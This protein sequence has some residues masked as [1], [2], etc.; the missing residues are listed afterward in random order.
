MGK[1][2]FSHV[3]DCFSKLHSWDFR[4]DGSV[5]VSTKFLTSNFYNKSTEMDAKN[6]FEFSFS[7]IVLTNFIGEIISPSGPSPRLVLG[8][9]VDRSRPRVVFPPANGNL[10][11][12]PLQT[13][14]VGIVVYL[15]CKRSFMFPLSR[16][17]CR[18]KSSCIYQVVYKSACVYISWWM[19][20]IC[21]LKRSFEKVL[22]ITS[23]SAQIGSKVCLHLSALILRIW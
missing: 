15:Q 20:S 17:A 18:R 11:L 12:Y 1:H 22:Y 3:F 4:E 2:S 16:Q 19:C 5:L 14:V 10:G 21:K 7:F 23:S 6:F 9:P 8:K 13:N